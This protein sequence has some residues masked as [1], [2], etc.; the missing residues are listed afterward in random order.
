MTPTTRRGF[1]L[2]LGVSQTGLEISYGSG[3]S[4]LLINP[5]QPTLKPKIFSGHSSHV[6]L[7]K[8]ANNGHRVVS[9]GEAGD[10]KVW[11]SDHPEL[12]VTWEK[13]TKGLMQDAVFYNDSKKVILVGQEMQG[14]FGE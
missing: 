10:L 14:K 2:S 5:H 13:Q 8:I 1:P 9:V 3:N 6:R 7:A 11:Q 4:A 12:I